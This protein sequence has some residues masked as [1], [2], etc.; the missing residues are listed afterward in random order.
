MNQTLEQ[1]LINE[2]ID[3]FIWEFGDYLAE[4]FDPSLFH[5]QVNFTIQGIPEEKVGY[6]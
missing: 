4:Q 2:D 5:G 3:S 1:Y 6:V